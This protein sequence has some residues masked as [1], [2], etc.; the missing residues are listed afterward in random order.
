[1]RALM[2]LPLLP[3]CA[4]KLL[5][6]M[7]LACPAAARNKVSFQRRPPA[8]AN[9]PRLPQDCALA[10]RRLTSATTAAWKALMLQVVAAVWALPDA[11]AL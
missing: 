4:K 10:R 5:A 3:V 7:S 8:A 6:T 1:M 2:V 11:V 9:A